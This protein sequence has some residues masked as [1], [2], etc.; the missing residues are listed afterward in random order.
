MIHDRHCKPKNKPTS[1]QERR[2]NALPTFR[3]ALAAQ[4]HEDRADSGVPQAAD[5]PKLLAASKKEQPPKIEQKPSSS[6]DYGFSVYLLGGD[7]PK[8]GGNVA[9]NENQK[10]NG[11]SNNIEQC[12]YAIKTDY[13]KMNSVNVKSPNDEL[14]VEKNPNPNVEFPVYDQD[15]AFTPDPLHGLLEQHDRIDPVR[16][17]FNMLPLGSSPAFPRHMVHAR[18]TKKKN[19]KGNGNSSL[20]KKG[21]KDGVPNGS[22]GGDSTVD[23]SADGDSVGDDSQTPNME[24]SGDS[25]NGINKTSCKSWNSAGNGSSA[26]D[27]VGDDG[28]TSDV[29]PF[30]D[31]TI[32]SNKTSCLSWN[33]NA[34][35]NDTSGCGMSEQTTGETAQSICAGETATPDVE[36]CGDSEMNTNNTC[37]KS[38]RDPKSKHKSKL[39]LT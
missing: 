11:A 6:H 38:W 25:K 26:D 36:T 21:N 8:S 35:G 32:D 17:E 23:R 4:H 9:H 12:K 19:S 34:V 2:E 37:C 5:V 1:L 27:S 3:C 18:S 20:T 29:E 30:G 13:N 7:Q 28:Q 14:R 39:T 15:L 16:K 33:D 22:E 31:L 24:A 10:T